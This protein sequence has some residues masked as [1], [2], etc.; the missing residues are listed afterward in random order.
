MTGLL[1]LVSFCSLAQT[2]TD[3][4]EHLVD[5][6]RIKLHEDIDAIQDK[7]E[8]ASMKRAHE[9]EG[10]IQLA[11]QI[12]IR[13]LLLR[14]SD[15]LQS[16]IEKYVDF[17]HRI[18]VKYLTGLN[19]LLWQLPEALQTNQITFQLMAESLEAFIVYLNLDFAGKSLLTP[20]RDFS[21]QVNELIFNDQTVFFDNIDLAQIRILIYRQFIEVNPE[22]I[23]STIQPYLDQPFADT[24]LIRAAVE[25]PASFYNYASATGTDVGKKIQQISHPL[26]STVARIALEPKARLIYPFLPS[27]LLGELTI[28]SIKHELLDDNKYFTLLVSTLQHYLKK[29]TGV[30][31]ISIR[32][33]NILIRKKA[34]E[35]Y[36]NEINALHDEPPPERFKVLEPLTMTALYYIIVNGEDILYT[37]SY[38]GV[39]LK[40]MS[41][42]GNASGDSL[43]QSV[44]YDRFRK[45]IR[46]AAGYNKLD[47]FLA[48]M[49][50]INANLLMRSFVQGLERGLSLEN[51]VDVADSYASI[52]NSEVTK[53]ISQE[54]SLQLELQRH[55]KNYRGVAIYDILQA[56][57][58]SNTDSAKSLMSKYSIPPVYGLTNTQLSDSAGMVVEQ[59][60]FYGDKDGIESFN[61]FLGLFRGRKEWQLIQREDWVEII[62][63]TGKPVRVYANL[64]HDNSGGD[65]LDARAQ[66]RLSQNLADSN[67]HPTIVVHRGHSYHLKYTL[68]QLPESARIVILGSCGSYQNLDAVLAVCPDAHIV[69]SK[70]VGTRLVNEPVLRIINESLRTGNG[71]NWVKVWKQLSA[72]LRDGYARERLDNYIPP[73]QNLGA[74]FIKAFRNW[75]K[76]QSSMKL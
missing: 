30:D 23:L 45:F 4:M 72:Q 49:P 70:E 52:D 64:P 53:R 48:S 1:L 28:D 17:D 63:K 33:I 69:S 67:L 12:L 58:R 5:I 43:L 32:E 29:G 26:V 76:Q 59:L 34:E 25:F 11:N 22:K 39:Y 19:K 21:Y 71:V 20:V 47:H 35:F 65:D 66:L 18:K 36:I 74:L 68:E 40:L 61:N 27:I 38:N 73:H 2:N 6:R 60:F 8:K 44:Q 56:I 51:A 37:S 46:M 14:R 15:S 13:D 54:I 57:F 55:K 50:D 24:L 7:I 16:A 62:A 75:E 41:L 3:G 9:L 31:E 10:N 42:M